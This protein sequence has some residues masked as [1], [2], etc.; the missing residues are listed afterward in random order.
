MYFI[1]PING[2]QI[3]NGTGNLEF[4]ILESAPGALNVVTSGNIKIYS[5]SILISSYAG[6]TGTD[7]NPTISA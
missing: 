5:C 2:T 7:F 6:L 3:N 1:S 4:D